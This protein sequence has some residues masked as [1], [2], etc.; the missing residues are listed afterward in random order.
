MK[1]ENIVVTVKLFAVYQETYQQEEITIELPYNSKVEKI[2]EK[3]LTDH[4]HLENEYMNSPAWT[5]F[6][7]DLYQ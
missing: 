6:I 1:S 4:P 2:L 3:I 5:D 7:I